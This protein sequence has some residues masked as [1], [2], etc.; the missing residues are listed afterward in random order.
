MEILK[1][2]LLRLKKGLLKDV[3]S[4]SLTSNGYLRIF[5]KNFIK[6]MG[7]YVDK[8]KGGS[9]RKTLSRE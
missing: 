2:L 6:D 3:L 4:A 7:F 9:K 1:R 5:G 8:P